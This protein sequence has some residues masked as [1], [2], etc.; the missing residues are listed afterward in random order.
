QEEEMDIDADPFGECSVV[1]LQRGDLRDF[2]SV[3]TVIPVYIEMPINELR[4]RFPEIGHWVKL[5]N[6]TFCTRSGLWQGVMS[7]QSKVHIIS[8][9]ME[10]RYKRDSVERLKTESRWPQWCPKTLDGITVTNCEGIRFSTLM[11]VITHSQ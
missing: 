9:E 4:P 1:P 8:S 3:G 11:D 7:Y 6:L 10:E 2:P 5:R